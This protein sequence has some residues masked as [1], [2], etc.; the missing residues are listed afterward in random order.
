M[1]QAQ[2]HAPGN[3]P[4]DP[5]KP[6]TIYYQ[7]G[8]THT[9]LQG[10]RVYD[11]VGNQHSPDIL[12]LWEKGMAVPFDL[13]QALVRENTRRKIEAEMAEKYL[14][15]ERESQA[16]LDR[17][18]AEIQAIQERENARIRGPLNTAPPEAPT[19]ATP[20]PFIMPEME[21]LDMLKALVPEAAPKVPNHLGLQLVQDYASKIREVTLDS[22]TAGM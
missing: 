9:H 12:P 4:Y 6:S 21:S 5:T 1:A 18:N 15:L 19:P 8:C 17:V 3:V 11:A 14:I 13:Q 22:P 20:A 16:S 10:G 2:I 7:A